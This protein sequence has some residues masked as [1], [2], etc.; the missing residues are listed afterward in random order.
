MGCRSSE[1]TSYVFK[2]E[3]STA[4]AVTPGQGQTVNVA[5]VR[6]GGDLAAWTSSAAGPWSEMELDKGE[7]SDGSSA[8]RRMLLRP[9]TGLKDMVVELDPGSRGRARALPEGEH[10]P[11]LPDRSRT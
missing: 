10:D 3:F 6:G 7:I 1:R 4:Q 2:G 11:R 9:K 5:G 8:T